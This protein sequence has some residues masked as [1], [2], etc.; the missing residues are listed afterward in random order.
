M[1]VRPAERYGKAKVPAD[2]RLA[3]DGRMMCL[4]CH[5]A[6]GAHLSAVRAFPGQAPED[7]ADTGGGLYRTFFL[8]RSDPE[9]GLAPLCEACHRMPR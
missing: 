9:R 7:P 4:T 8:R 3:D 6:H 1:D 5:V 2:L